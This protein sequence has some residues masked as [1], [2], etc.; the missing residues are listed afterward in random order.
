MAVKIM[1]K[2]TISRLMLAQVNGLKSSDGYFFR[3]D[4]QDVLSGVFLEYVPTGMYIYDFKFPLFDFSGPNLTYGDRLN[5]KDF[6]GKGEMS[7]QAMVECILASSEAQK[8]LTRNA[9]LS[10]KDF[11][12]YLVESNKCVRGGHAR[13]IYATALV[14]LDQESRAVDIL[15]ELPPMLHKKDIP[16]CQ[17]LSE[18]LRLGPDAT[19][20]LLNQIRQKNLHAFGLV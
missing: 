9:P 6:I 12:D 19:R 20:T 10:V 18:S 11:A 8:A 14:L 5:G 17:T 7:E 4:F 16:H 13:L 2:T 15:E 3:G 1:K